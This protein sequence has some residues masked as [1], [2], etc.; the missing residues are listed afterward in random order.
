V[1][2]YFGGTVLPTLGVSVLLLDVRGDRAVI[3]VEAPREVPVHRQEVWL[4]TGGCLR[5]AA[6]SPWWQPASTIASA[7]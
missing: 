3:G 7:S 6:R 2:A 4:E 5:T 1:A